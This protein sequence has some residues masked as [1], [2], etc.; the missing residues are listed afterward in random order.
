MAGQLVIQLGSAI[1]M[2]FFISFNVVKYY[3][4]VS[5]CHRI[6]Q[7]AGK[8]LKERIEVKALNV[9]KYFNKISIQF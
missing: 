4:F 5:L 6:C 8:N 9:S 7:V 3:G 2:I 1:L